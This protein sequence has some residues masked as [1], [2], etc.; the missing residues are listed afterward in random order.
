MGDISKY[1]RQLYILFFVACA[2]SFRMLPGPMFLDDAYITFRMADNLAAGN[3]FVYNID[4]RVLSSTTPLYVIVLALISL[5]NLSVPLI[6]FTLNAIL[7]AVTAFLL[8]SAC[9][10]MCR[11]DEVSLGVAFLYAVS[12]GSVIYAMAGMETIF[13]EFVIVLSCIMIL[14]KHDCWAAGLAGILPLIRPEGIL[15]SLLLGISMI[16]IKRRRVFK[17]GV[18]AC[19]PLC[20]W[21]LWALY[22][23][24]DVI[25]HSVREKYTFFNDPKYAVGITGFCRQWMYH[26]YSIF[27]DNPISESNLWNTH[28]LTII[29]GMTPFSMCY[30]YGVHKAIHNLRYLPLLLS[31]LFIAFFYIIGR[32]GLPFQWYYIPTTGLLILGAFYGGWCLLSDLVQGTKINLLGRLPG[33][34]CFAV[35]VFM[36]LM[37]VVLRYE[38]CPKLRPVALNQHVPAYRES[39]YLDAGRWINKRVQGYDDLV[40]CS[41]VGALGYAVNAKVWDQHLTTPSWIGEGGDALVEKYKPCFISFMGLNPPV[42]RLREQ[43]E[44]AEIGAEGLKYRKVYECNRDA[45]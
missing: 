25:P 7:G 43:P 28:F 39:V 33:W 14:R 20:V 5:F 8:F 16:G 27:W 44:I 36:C 42:E 18:F 12:P 11:N 41:E 26:V 13:F 23:Y 37:H 10:M 21:L 19:L 9:R 31:P 35:A 34:L 24:G 38:Y 2:F 30:L 29:V 3:G 17:Y 45:A 4:E 32:G 6:A 15:I 40:L 1:K 22:Y